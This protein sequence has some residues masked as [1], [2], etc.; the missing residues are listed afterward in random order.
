VNVD[1]AAAV[2]LAAD[3]KVAAV[4][5]D[6]LRQAQGVT[7]AAPA[8]AGHRIRDRHHAILPSQ[9]RSRG[10]H[11]RHH[12]PYTPG[13]HSSVPTEEDFLD[14]TGRGEAYDSGIDG[15]G[16]LVGV[17]DTGIWPEHPSFADDGTLPEAPVLAGD[18]CQF[19]N[20]AANPN[21]KDFTCNN[22]L[23]GAR[24]MTITYR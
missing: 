11:G 20:T 22:K 1:H 16:V 7:A 2:R 24:D 12:P 3:P 5:P 14:L 23:V 19:G 9:S 8:T 21:D 10:G 13:H 4:V 15:E 6:D 17:I 18:S